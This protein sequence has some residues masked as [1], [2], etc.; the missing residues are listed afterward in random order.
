MSRLGETCASGRRD[1]VHADGWMNV[2]AVLMSR[3]DGKLTRGSLN[4]LFTDCREQDH[5]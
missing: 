4:E 2:L 1:C 5:T 3:V